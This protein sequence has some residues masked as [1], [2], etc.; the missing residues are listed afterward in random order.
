M[1]ASQVKCTAQLPAG[2]HVPSIGRDY[3]V[4]QNVDSHNSPAVKS[5]TPIIP[6]SNTNSELY[7]CT[8]LLA[9]TIEVCKCPLAMTEDGGFAVCQLEHVAMH[10]IKA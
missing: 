2:R 8:N 3:E 4:Q 7:C 1:A 6:V 5:S 10:G 9:Q